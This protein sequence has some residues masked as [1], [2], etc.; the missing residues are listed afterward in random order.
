MFSFTLRHRII[1]L[2]GPR[3]RVAFMGSIREGGGSWS[4][5]ASAEEEKFIHE[6]ERD[7]LAKLNAK[8]AENVKKNQAKATEDEKDVVTQETLGFATTGGRTGVFTRREGA[9]EEKWIR[10]HEKEKK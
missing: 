3:T 9:L 7:V 1:T 2:L 6:H 10:D 8:I 4:A 5:K